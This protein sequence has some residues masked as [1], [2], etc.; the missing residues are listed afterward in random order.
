VGRCGIAGL[1][2]K[3]RLPSATPKLIGA[4]TPNTTTTM[5]RPR[6]VRRTAGD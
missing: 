6:A 4:V 1:Q 3:A 5:P 2:A